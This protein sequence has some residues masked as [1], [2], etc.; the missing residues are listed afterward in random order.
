MSRTNPGVE[1][2]PMARIPERQAVFF[3]LDGVVMREARLDDDGQVPYF[4]G[5]LEAL[6]RIDPRR[7]LLF[8]A[9]GREDI[10]FGLLR[11]GTSR[12]SATASWRLSPPGACGLPRSTAAPT[13]PR[14]VAGSRRPPCFANRRPACSRWPNRSS[15]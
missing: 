10:A 2:L 12:S 11:E 1:D 9:T 15:T 3:E 13:T 4:P 7:F 6:A 14:G 8:A 5:A